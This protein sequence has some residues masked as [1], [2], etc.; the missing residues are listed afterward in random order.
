M[1]RKSYQITSAI[2][3]RLLE[4]YR[5][6]GENKRI[7]GEKLDLSQQQ[8]GKMMN[9]KDA[10]ISLDT[11]MLLIERLP[12]LDLSAFFPSCTN[13]PYQLV[14]SLSSESIKMALFY[15]SLNLDSRK[16]FKLFCEQLRSEQIQFLN[17]TKF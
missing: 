16:K 15:D 14:S 10:L 7:L 11:I 13:C 5:L 6:C 2:R 3:L 9:H 12:G 1:A 8:I 4:E 17:S